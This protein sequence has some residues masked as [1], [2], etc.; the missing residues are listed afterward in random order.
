MLLGSLKVP[1]WEIRRRILEID[2]QKCRET[3]LEQLVNM[4]P[5]P[6]MIATVATFKD[7]Y[8]QMFESEQ[9][10]ST[11][12][13]IKEVKHKIESIIFKLNFEEIVNDIKPQIFCTTNALEE[14]QKSDRFKQLLEAI[15]YIGNYVNSGSAKAQALGFHIKYLPSL[16]NTRSTVDPT[17]TML[18]FLVDFLEKNFPDLLTF[19]NDF[20]DLFEAASKP[21]EQ[22]D[23]KL[24]SL[25]KSIKQLKADVQNAKKMKK[26]LA[27][28]RFVPV[29]E[30][31][32]IEA[33]KRY[34]II[35][36]LNNKKK[37]MY[38]CVAKYFAFK[39]NE[40]GID[41]CL[42]DI[43]QFV[44][45]FRR[46]RDEMAQKRELEDRKRRQKEAKEAAERLY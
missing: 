36:T 28:D 8:D 38:E 5:D 2:E 29:M 3:N 31:F 33:E 19:Y 12:C 10:L 22:I 15:L 46:I 11:I 34:D 13:D 43:K 7:N 23:Q 41:S 35:I 27:D 24:N 9:F 25:A 26:T 18:H 44:S 30:E 21:D 40:Y 32:S 14:I 45:E 6:E 42:N 1:F 37:N 17:F 20:D 4:L 39:T 16:I